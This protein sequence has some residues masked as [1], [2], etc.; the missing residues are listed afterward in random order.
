M[1]K[2]FIR[3]TCTYSTNVE[4]IDKETA[5]EMAAVADLEDWS[6]DPEWSVMEAEA[7][8]KPDDVIER[9]VNCSAEINLSIDGY[10]RNKEDKHYW[11]EPCS[12]IPIRP[13]WGG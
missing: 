4:A 2:F 3:I 8:E 1:P 12:W 7:M 6:N 11:C 10:Y 5:L 9:C 13:S